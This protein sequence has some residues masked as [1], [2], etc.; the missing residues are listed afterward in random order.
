MPDCCD[1][2]DY[3]SVFSGRFARRRA[4]RYHRR[5][6]TPAAA[7]IVDFA[8]T[9]IEGSTVLEI[10]GGVGELHVE[11]LQRGATHVTNLEISSSYEEEGA[12]LLDRAGLRRRVT[13]RIVDLAQNPDEVEPADVVVLHRVVCCYPDFATLL[14]A[15]SSTQPARWSLPRRTVASPPT[16][17]DPG[18]G[19]SSAWSDESTSARAAKPTPNAAVRQDVGWRRCRAPVP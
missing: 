16:V 6:L 9:N 7:R 3:T 17:T 15:R 2:G 19:T 10:G 14:L 1:P 12:Q 13:R 5:G 11:L 18:N 4:R 8:A